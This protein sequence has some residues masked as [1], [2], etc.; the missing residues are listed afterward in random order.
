[1]LLFQTSKINLKPD[2]SDM[3]IVSAW[4]VAILLNVSVT[5]R[6]TNLR[7]IQVSMVILM[8]EA[9]RSTAYV[10]VEYGVRRLASAG[11]SVWVGARFGCGKVPGVVSLCRRA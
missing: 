6:T 3:I 5:D 11:R 10:G 2:K 4:I 1:M 9:S 7:V 8:T